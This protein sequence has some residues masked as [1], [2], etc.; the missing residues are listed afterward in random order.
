MKRVCSLALAALLFGAMQATAAPI[1]SGS[2]NSGDTF[3]STDLFSFTNSSTAG[4]N[5]TQIAITI[6]AAFFFDTDVASPGNAP[7]GPTVNSSSSITGNSFN[8]TDGTSTLTVLF[9]QF[10]PTEQFIFGVDVD[11]VATPDNTVLGSDLLGTS[12]VVTFSD[13]SIFRGTFVDDG[14][15][16]G[17]A[18]TL[19]GQLQVIPEPSSLALFGLMGVAAAAYYRR[20]KAQTV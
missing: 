17:P 4:E 18:G 12:V 16:G 1:V 3:L 10:N 19:Q 14:V 9:T 11:S 2:L 7:S 8:V 13:G 20:R 15:P 6:P 5:I